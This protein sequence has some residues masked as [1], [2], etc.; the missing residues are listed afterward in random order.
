MVKS[1]PELPLVGATA[2]KAPRETPRLLEI[3]LD[4]I[5]DMVVKMT[6]SRTFKI[7]V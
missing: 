3:Y 5:E 7:H 1:E 2:G 4:L 6:N